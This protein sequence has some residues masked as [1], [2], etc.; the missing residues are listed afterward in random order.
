MRKFFGWIEQVFDDN[1]W[2]CFDCKRTQPH[3]TKRCVYCGSQEVENI[4]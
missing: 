3:Q 2:Y 1:R 4:G